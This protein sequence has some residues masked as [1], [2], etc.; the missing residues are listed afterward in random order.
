MTDKQKMDLQIIADKITS[1]KSNLDSARHYLTEFNKKYND[2]FEVFQEHKGTYLVQGI[3][4]LAVLLFDFWVSEKSLWYLFQIIRVKV[5]Y[6]AILFS[7][8][9]GG[10]AILAIGGLAGTNLILRKK[11]QKTW[12]P[13][14]II[15]AII[16]VILFFI[17]IY[18]YYI[19][20]DENGK[21]LFEL[22]SLG[23]IKTILPQV[24]FIAIIYFVLGKAGFGL[25]Y[26]IG[27]F[28]FGTWKFL[29]A[30]PIQEETKL[31]EQINDFKTTSENFG[32]D[33]I[34]TAKQ[35]N[36]NTFFDNY[37]RD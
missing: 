20:V 28:Y 21:V 30:S 31:N 37:N 1:I 15:L 5:E 16:K 24:F 33:V 18:N 32:L 4:C 35:F 2:F 11:M 34:Q 26:V 9:D 19:H 29:L 14:L 13:V 8:I 3:I 12:R 7:L 27:T 6:L 22:G 10:I 23:M 17:L 25:W 36:V